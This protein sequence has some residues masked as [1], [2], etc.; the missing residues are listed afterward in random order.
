VAGVH[1]DGVECD[2]LLSEAQG[3]LN[4]IGVGGMVKMHGNRNGGR[5]RAKV[6][7]VNLCTRYPEISQLEAVFQERTFSVG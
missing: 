1:H 4:M 2:S 5:V 7:L 6:Y 3:E